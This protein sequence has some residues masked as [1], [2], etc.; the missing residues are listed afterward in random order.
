MLDHSRLTLCMF[1]LAMVAFNP[2]GLALNKISSTDSSSIPGGRT[3]LG[4]MLKIDCIVLYKK[5][6][7]F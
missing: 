1:M 3:I 5:K 4:C 7:K 6:R 2:F